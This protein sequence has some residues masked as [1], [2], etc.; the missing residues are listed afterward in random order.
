MTKSSRL[1]LVLC[2]FFVT[3]VILAEF[4][5]IKIFAFGPSIGLEPIGWSVFGQ[6]GSLDLTAGVLLWPV[7]FILT[8]ITNE[9]F[10]PRGVRFISWLTTGLIIYAFIFAYLAIQLVPA[11]W[12][13]GSY[14]AQGVPDVQ[15]AFAA[16][17]GQGMWAIGGSI[18]A[19]LVAQLIDVSVFQAVRKRTGERWLWARATGSTLISQ[20]IDTFLV[21][22]IAF[23]LGPQQ[24]PLEKMLA[25]GGVNYLYKLLVALALTPVIYLAHAWLQR[26][27]GREESIRMKTEAHA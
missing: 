26:W 15:A 1:F 4:I 17:F 12:W 6:S 2:T 25:I 19:F 18:C 14:A 23:V 24:W 21:L 11:A 20:F 7:V 10:G 16:I 22:Y 5:G 27:L 13:P 3:N 9:Y 8:D